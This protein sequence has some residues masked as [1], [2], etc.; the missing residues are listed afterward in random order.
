LLPVTKTII[1]VPGKAVIA[2]VPVIKEWW[3]IK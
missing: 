3:A 2:A 1:Q